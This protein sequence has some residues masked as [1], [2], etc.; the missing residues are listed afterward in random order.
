[1]VAVGFVRKEGA[2]HQEVTR[3]RYL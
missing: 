3:W 1:M 2:R